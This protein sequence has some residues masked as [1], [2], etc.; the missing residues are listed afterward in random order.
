MPQ[1]IAVFATDCLRHGV[2]EHHRI[3]TFNSG[4]LVLGFRILLYSYVIRWWRDLHLVVVGLAL[5]LAEKVSSTE[6]P[7]PLFGKIAVIRN[8]WIRV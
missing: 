5:S 4:Q 6:F 7:S 8:M 1:R 2:I 3:Q